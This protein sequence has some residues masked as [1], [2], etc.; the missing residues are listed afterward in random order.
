MTSL[1]DMHCHLDFADNAKEVAAEMQQ[2]AITALC[3]TV[4]PSS[5]VAAVEEFKPWPNVQVALGVHPWWIAQDRIGEV[6]LARFASLAPTT[7]FIGEIGLDF[8]GKR[9]ETQAH[10]EE[11]LYRLLSV[12]GDCTDRKVVF[13][14]GVRAG[15]Q[16]LSMLDR[17][18]T[19]E[20]H[21]CVFH[22]FQG[23]P[24]DFGR[25]LAM[26]CWFSVGMRMLATDAGRMFAQAVPAER[27]VVE[28]DNPPHEG[29]PWSSGMWS[30]ELR[31][32][33]RDLAELRGTSPEELQALLAAN[34]ESLLAIGADLRNA[35]GAA[36]FAAV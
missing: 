15:D 16:L 33:V 32:T 17:C 9:K 26:D 35:E 5:Y 28:T 2:A 3:A 4:V 7:P 20:Q 36:G 10:Q 13:L 31:N 18:R 19:A 29:M 27:L 6:D 21:T 23:T 22:W 14:H 34:S 24:D 11:V 1:Y 12:L 25:A 8:H 30:E